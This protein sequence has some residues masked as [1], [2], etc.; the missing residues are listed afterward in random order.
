MDIEGNDVV[1]GQERCCYLQIYIVE[2]YVVI[3][4]CI[5]IY[6]SI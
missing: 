6:I 1:Y 5:G 3:Y 4:I 2:G